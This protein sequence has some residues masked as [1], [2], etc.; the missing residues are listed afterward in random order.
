MQVLNT[1]N[2]ALVAG[3]TLAAADLFTDD[4][5]WRDLVTF[6]WN[7]KTM[8]GKAAIA[9]MLSSQL[10][11]VKPTGWRIADG[12]V[13]AEDGGITTAWISF[14]IAVSRGYGLIRLRDGL[15]W[16]LL[17]SMVELKGHEEAWS[18]VWAHSM[19]QK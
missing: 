18:V 12:E 11:S 3:D 19:A 1:F 4:S 9:D 17:T 6:T 13:A 10:A 7:I 15:I 8:E 5:Y 16:T 14:E 2:G